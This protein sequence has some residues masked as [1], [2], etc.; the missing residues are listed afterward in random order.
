M[1]VRMLF[2]V[3][4]VLAA[5]KPNTPNLEHIL[6]KHFEAMGGLDKL[7]SVKATRITAVSGNEPWLSPIVFESKQPGFTRLYFK[8]MGMIEDNFATSPK[9]GWFSYAFWH[10]GKPDEFDIK[11]RK[12]HARQ[13]AMNLIF[14]YVGTSPFVG[15]KTKGLNVDYLGLADYAEG[16]AHKVSLEYPDDGITLIYFLDAKSYLPAKVETKYSALE[17]KYPLIAFDN[18]QKVD[19]VNIAYAWTEFHPANDSSPA[20]QTQG[21]IQKIEINPKIADSRFLPQAAELTK[22]R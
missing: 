10:D 18:Y 13:H 15:Y 14:S 9:G 4:V 19:G 20:S 7:A 3:P 8:N 5:Q 12:A 22:K 2:F 6:A 11:G 1:P 21:T 16:K 17:S